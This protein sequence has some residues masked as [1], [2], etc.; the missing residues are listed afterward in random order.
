MTTELLGAWIAAFLTLAIFSFLY[1]DNPV[2][3]FAEHLFIGVSAGYV[4]IMQIKDT[5]IPNLFLPLQKLF[6]EMDWSSAPR[7]G[8]LVLGAMVLMRFSQKLSWISRWPLAVLVGTYAALRMTG[9]AQSD[10][11]EQVNGTMVPLAGKDLPFF[12]WKGASVFNHLVLIVGVFSVLVYFF[13]SIERKKG[14]GAISMVGTFFLMVTFGS[15]F[16]YTVLGRVSLLIGR[17]Q[18][19]Y[20]YNQVKFGFPSLVCAALIILMIVLWEWKSP[21]EDRG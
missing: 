19:L 12:A 9:Y 20:S 15:S 16:G 7:L 10:L 6:T 11:V 17:T 5:L 14:L 4:L 3:K 2:Y 1:K 8:A 13:F 18:A 21:G